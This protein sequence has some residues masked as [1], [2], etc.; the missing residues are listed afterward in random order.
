VVSVIEASVIIQYSVLVVRSEY[1]RNIVVVAHA[2]PALK[3][4]S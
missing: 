3:S 2:T 4:L 1:T